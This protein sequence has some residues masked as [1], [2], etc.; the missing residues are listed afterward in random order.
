MAMTARVPRLDG[1]PW[2]ITGY[3]DLGAVAYNPPEHEIVDHHIW[4]A[5]NGKWQLWACIR[6][7]RI[8]RLFFGWEGDALEQ[9]NWRP[10]GITMRVDNACGESIN[11]W[12]GEDWLQS[13]FVVEQGGVYHMLYGG[14]NTEMGEC[15]M[16]LATSKDGRTFERHKNAQG[17]SRVFVGPGRDARPGAP[18]GG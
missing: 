8:G 14:H 17:F 1:D 5:R 11:D 18:Q 16:C 12:Q 13:P 3:P 7:A 9:T 6:S 15:Q 2:Y 4:Q 10:L